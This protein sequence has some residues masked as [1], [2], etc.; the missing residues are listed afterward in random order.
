MTISVPR[1]WVPR[2]RVFKIPFDEWRALY[3]P[4]LEW[5]TGKLRRNPSTGKIVRAV[6]SGITGALLRSDDTYN[7]CGCDCFDP[8]RDCAGKDCDFCGGSPSPRQW[9]RPTDWE[10]IL[11]GTVIAAQ[12]TCF[13]V[14]GGSS[15]LTGGTADGTYC[16]TAGA[17]CSAGRQTLTM[18][19]GSVGSTWLSSAVCGGSP[20]VTNRIGILTNV[21]FDGYSNLVDLLAVSGATTAVVGRI[22]FKTD[23][24]GPAAAK[25]VDSFTVGG[26][27]EVGDVFTIKLVRPDTGVELT[28][29][30][31]ATTTSLVTTAGGLAT[32]FTTAV[33]AID[34][35]KRPVVN[36]GGGDN[37][38]VTA[39]HA[40]IAHTYNA[41]TTTESG[42]G[43]AD[44][45]TLTKTAVTANGA[46]TKNCYAARSHTNAQAVGDL[47]Y[48]I[49]TNIVGHSGTMTLL[50]CCTPL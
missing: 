48:D 29:T 49:S 8:V 16:L 40:G 46:N 37:F 24:V 23:T 12:P 13:T 6:E 30:H 17:G 42:G 19:G 2:P 31:T 28:I 20:I 14:N 15:T 25:Q 35:T 5:F 11:H 44:G 32:A 50:A 26:T 36:Y 10:V 4:P 1:L 45:Q 33:G 39:Q 38:S 22:F 47:A 41:V 21:A 27:V 3:A 18:A 34:A 43:P 9:Q 7:V